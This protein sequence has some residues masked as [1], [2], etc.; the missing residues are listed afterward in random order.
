MRQAIGGR[1]TLQLP[2]ASPSAGR[3]SCGP[4]P[5]HRLHREGGNRDPP[6]PGWSTA[7]GLSG[8][9]IR[10][11]PLRHRHVPSEP[12][13]S[14][15]AARW[16]AARRRGGYR[17]S[18]GSD[19]PSRGGNRPS[20]RPRRG[21]DRSSHRPSREF[22]RPSHRGS[23]PPCGPVV[24]GDV[25]HD[26]QAGPCLQRISD[27]LEAEELESFPAKTAHALGRRRRGFIRIVRAEHGFD[28]KKTSR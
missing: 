11:R 28:V 24:R 15:V 25:G 9:G 17:G 20:H 22:D 27:S 2:A 13:S 21:F 6:H 19:R 16:R 3:P 1:K 14:A 18:H 10:G 26:E 7:A 5:P 4:A 8:A 12:G 23:S